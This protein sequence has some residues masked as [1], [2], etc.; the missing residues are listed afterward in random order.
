[1]VEQEV[2]LKFMHKPQSQP[3]LAHLQAQSESA[4]YFTWLPILLGESSD[5]LKIISKIHPNPP[6]SPTSARTTLNQFFSFQ[7]PPFGDLGTGAA[8][9]S[10]ASGVPPFHFLYPVWV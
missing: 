4:H 2:P 5:S 10:Q 9:L 3:L 8:A 1:M 7:E 6:S